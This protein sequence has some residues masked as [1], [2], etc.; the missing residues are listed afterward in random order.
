MKRTFEQYKAGI[1]CKYQQDCPFLKKGACLYSHETVETCEMPCLT[2]TKL[3]MPAVLNQ[4]KKG[5]QG[6]LRGFVLQD[7]KLV[8]TYVE[9]EEWARVR[10][11]VE[12]ECVHECSVPCTLTKAQREALVAQ[13]SFKDN[14]C[15]T[16]HGPKADQAAGLTVHYRAKHSE[17]KDKLLDSI[18]ALATEREE[19]KKKAEEEKTTTC[20]FDGEC[21][22]RF[23]KHPHAKGQK[24]RECPSAH[25]ENP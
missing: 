21:D 19:E 1:P 14:M 18:K 15:L 22:N 17:D 11:E 12:R 13:Y 10:S 2:G 25:C 23:C 16:F 20:K 7:T 8:V 3:Y 6:A 5:S 9:N 4:V 24:L